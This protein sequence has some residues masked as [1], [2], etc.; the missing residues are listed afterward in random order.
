VTRLLVVDTETGGVDPQIHSIFSLAAIVWE[1][2]KLGAEFEVLIVEPLLA[3]TGRALEINGID[4]VDHCKR[5]VG[6]ADAVARLQ[7]F[8]RDHFPEELGSRNKISLAGHNVNFDVG[9]MKRLFRLA[10][11]SYEDMF[12]H[13]VMDTAGLL[14][15]LT[16]AKKLP[17]SGAGADEA[18]QYFGIEVPKGKRHT[19]LGDARATALLLNKLIDIVK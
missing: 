19:A 5:G 8:L 2:G 13:R 6:P 9:F 7:S 18:F 3:V 4:I 12:S 10:G 11:L 15:F 1:D 17:L 16:L 14:R